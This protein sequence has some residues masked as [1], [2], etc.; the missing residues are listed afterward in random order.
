[1]INLMLVMTMHCH[2]GETINSIFSEQPEPLN[3]CDLNGKT[4]FLQWKAQYEPCD[5]PKIEVKTINYLL[6]PDDNLFLP[7]EIQRELNVTANDECTSN[8]LHIDVTL[9]IHLNEYIL[10]QDYI[11]CIITRST[12]GIEPDRSEKLYLQANRNCFSTTAGNQSPSDATNVTTTIMETSKPSPLFVIRN[13][14]CALHCNRSL[15]YIILYFILCVFV[16]SLL[17]IL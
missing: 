8:K 10:E 2:V 7:I 6:Y 5:Y 3:L 14:S 13:A 4:I 15:I 17:A 9:S 1:M 12:E 16:I 11:V